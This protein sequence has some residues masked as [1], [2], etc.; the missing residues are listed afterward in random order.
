M[1]Q[2]EA[3][4][5]VPFRSPTEYFGY[6]WL[7]LCPC[8]RPFSCHAHTLGSFA[9]VQ[10]SLFP[11]IF[12]NVGGNELNPEDIAIWLGIHCV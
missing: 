4:S 9:K 6:D 5:H 11:G 7:V 12:H 1:L 8:L 3:W 2:I 10:G